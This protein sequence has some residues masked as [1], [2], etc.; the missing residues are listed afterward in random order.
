TF[1]AMAA[2]GFTLDNL[3]LMALTIS[4]GF[5][6][7]DAIVVL[8]NIVRHIEAGKKPLEAAIEGGGQVAFTIVSITLSLVAVF[9]P[10][11]LMGGVVGRLFREFG[12]TVSAAIL[13]SA[14]VSLTLSPMLCGRLMKPVDKTRTAAAGTVSRVAG[15]IYDRGFGFYRWSL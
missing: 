11:F 3:S 10:V 4:V 6:V 2:F 8:E 7:D 1:V 14:A 15:Q 12:I 5:V 9:I 13:A